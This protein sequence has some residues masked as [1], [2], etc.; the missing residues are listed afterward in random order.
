[1]ARSQAN[2]GE[3]KDQLV[4]KKRDVEKLIHESDDSRDEM[5]SLQAKSKQMASDLE[6]IKS[7]QVMELK[8]PFMK[9]VNQQPQEYST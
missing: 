1:L 4:Q 9:F 5:R 6:K 3:L 2:I 8:G 7:D